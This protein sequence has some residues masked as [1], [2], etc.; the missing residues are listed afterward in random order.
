MANA[1]GI[2]RTEEQAVYT[3]ELAEQFAKE[4]GVPPRPQ[5]TRSEIDD[6]A[7]LSVSRMPLSSHLEKE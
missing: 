2:F 1:C 6:G 3:D 5:E 7:L 4:A